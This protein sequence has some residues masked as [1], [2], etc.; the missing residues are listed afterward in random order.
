VIARDDQPA[1]AT[2]RQAT[3]AQLP[4]DSKVKP[5]RPRPRRAA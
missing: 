4:G 5:L 3:A 2:A 1:S